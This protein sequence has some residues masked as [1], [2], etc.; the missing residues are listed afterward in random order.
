MY[1]DLEA[2]KEENAA[3]TYEK[4][5][6]QTR[7]KR[8]NRSGE[9]R[10]RENEEEAKR[11]KKDRANQSPEAKARESKKEAQRKQKERENQSAET[12]A[13]VNIKDAQRKQ[14]DRVNQ[15]PET[16]LQENE[17]AAK[18]MEELRKNQSP[19]TK[20][21]ENEEAAKRMEELRKNQSPETKARVNKIDAQR[22]QKDRENQSPET[23]LQENEE[24]AKRM[25]RNWNKKY[26]KNNKT[27]TG[28]MRIFLNSVR[29]GCTYPCCCCQETKYR[30][31]VTEILDMAKYKEELDEK[32]ENFFAE[33]IW[34][35]NRKGSFY[36]CIDCKSKLDKGKM[37][38][39]CRSNKL[40]IFDIK[41]YPDLDLTELELNLISKKIIFMKIHRKPKSQ[42]SAI[43]DRV[44][45]IPID[46]GTIEQTLKKLPRLP[47]EAGLVPIKLKRKQAYKSSHL[48][49]WVNVEK[50][51][52]CLVL[53]KN[54]GHSE[55][56]FYSPEDFTSYVSR[57]KV[58]D[59]EGYEMLFDPAEYE[60]SIDDD[61][62]ENENIDDPENSKDRKMESEKESASPKLKDEDEALDEIEYA[63][64]LEEDYRLN[65]PCAKFQ[66]NYDQTACFINDAPETAVKTHDNNE[67]ISVSPGEG[68]NLRH[69]DICFKIC[70][71]FQAK[72][73]SQSWRTHSGTLRA[74][75]FLIQRWRTT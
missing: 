72:F 5:K 34:P 64:K 66:F 49:E 74:T 36:L 24:A 59:K 38:A 71:S 48:Q 2:I 62:L 65:D 39:K 37:P 26:V 53:L 1:Y 54:F 11:K 42:M 68:E 14:K 44:V 28:R 63:E 61:S 17:K 41:D 69:F 22:K 6:Q 35:C 58:E 10:D 25:K 8:A 45:C 57:C 52:R 16:K 18:R 33:T 50:I 15:S 70:F 3:R 31:G 12:K 67:A 29:D 19:E 20:L 13:R 40:E 21:Q 60:M 55:Y 27:T 56:Q 51:F 30:K 9:E 43:K 4:K 32:R 73:L 23:K 7:N 46:S 75:P 47:K